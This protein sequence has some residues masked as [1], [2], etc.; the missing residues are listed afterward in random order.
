MSIRSRYHH[1]DL[2]SALLQRAEATLRKVGVDG[3]SLRQLARDIGVSHAAPSRHFR[4]KQA[5]LD[6]LAATGFDRLGECFAHTVTEG[7]VTER[8]YGMA[9]AYLRFAVENPELLALMFARKQ[10]STSPELSA[11]VQRAFAVPVDL[12]AVGQAEGEIVAG[13]P[14]RLG[15]TAI[16]ALQGVATIVA[17]DFTS[18]YDAD[19]LL[20]DMVR[21]LTHGLRPRP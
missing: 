20:I 6:Q 13:D 3:L 8:L 14:K 5:L 9:R 7:P 17:S 10:R 4:D 16:A 1:G 15:L 11:A 12:I 18:D 2:R 19:Q 21:H